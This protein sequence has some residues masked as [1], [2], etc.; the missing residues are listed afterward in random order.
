M[1]KPRTWILVA[2]GARARIVR[3]GPEGEHLEDLAFEAD[4]KQ[5]KEIMA[6]KPGRSFASVGA[7]RSAVEYHSDP[8]RAQAEKFAELLVARLE[9]ARLSHEFDRLAIV[10]EPRMLGVIRSHMPHQL[11]ATVIAEVHKDL[12]KLPAHQLHEAVLTLDI[13]GLFA[14]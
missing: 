2:D 10:A 12:T 14:A 8:V 4:H 5:L 3:F 11:G 9:H 7:K 6:D 1:K 13:P